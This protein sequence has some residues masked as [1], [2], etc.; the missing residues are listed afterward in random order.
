[1]YEMD[2]VAK[3]F[4]WAHTIRNSDRQTRDSFRYISE[5]LFVPDLVAHYVYETSNDRRYVV[6]WHASD[7]SYTSAIVTY[8]H[9]RMHVIGTYHAPSSDG[10]MRGYRTFHCE[11]A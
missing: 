11:R 3:A 2:L 10:Y 1:M 6:K 7:T 8:R 4:E 5:Q 9:V